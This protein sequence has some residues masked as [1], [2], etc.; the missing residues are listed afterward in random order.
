MIRAFF[1]AAALAYS[2]A[3]TVVT[4]AGSGS[5]GFVDGPG[6]GAS[7]RSPAGVAVDASGNVF[8]GDTDNNSL[9]KITPGGVVTS[10]AGS[11]VASFADGTGAGAAF[12]WPAGVAVDDASGKVVVA[13]S[14]NH[15]IRL[16][17]PGGVVSTL[18]GDGYTDAFGAG[19]FADGPGA[20]A[21]FFLPMGVVFDAN[22]NAFVADAMNNRIRK[23]TPGGAVSTVAGSG[24]DAF[25][26]GIG[27]GAAFSGPASIAVDAYDNLLVAEMFGH[28]IRKVS[29]GGMVRTIAGDGYADNNGAGRWADGVGTAA[30]FSS[31]SGV[32]VAASGNIVVSDS[33]NNRI[34]VVTPGGVVGTLA[35]NGAAAFA[36]GAGATASFYYPVGVAVD[37]SGNVFVADEGNHRIR[38]VTPPSETPSGTISGTRSGTP[39]STPSGTP[40]ATLSSS[41]SGTPSATLSGTPSST[42]SGTR[43][44][45]L[46]GTPSGTRSG[47]PSGTLTATPSASVT[48]SA[49]PSNSPTIS[50]SPTPSASSLACAP[51]SFVAPGTYSCAR[52]PA[53]T[54]A[55]AA[56]SNTA[57]E[58]CP[59]PLVANANATACA[60]CPLHTR[61]NDTACTPCPADVW[62]EGGRELPCLL[63]GQCLGNLQGCRTGHTGFLCASCA[64][65][66][67]KA[68][69]NFCSPC[70]AQLW[71]ALAWLGGA[72]ALLG[73]VGLFLQRQLRSTYTGLAIVLS[74]HQLILTLV[75]DQ[76]MRLA[77]LNRLAVLAL[78]A[79]FKW[80]L[81]FAGLVFGFNTASAATECAN[82]GWAF[83]QMWGVVA[84]ATFF[85]L[86]L[87]LCVDLYAQ[88]MAPSPIAVAEW[89]VWDAMDALLP[90]AVQASWQALS[91]E[92]I[93]GEL[94]LLSEPSTRV[95]EYPHYAIY[96]A[97]VF[98]V[99]LNLCVTHKCGGG[100]GAKQTKK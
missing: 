47:T 65:H 11:G 97:S 6:A 91:S 38:L 3:Q 66:H 46:S 52:C 50:L 5:Q 39:S 17:T 95:F 56:G 83:A 89:R 14:L 10:L 41:P 21:S 88:R 77:L 58:P 26:D 32:A 24:A 8:V 87:T 25:A 31:P 98:I 57:C 51:G 30:S 62:C 33:A 12:Y 72:A 73:A 53:N 96:C 23:V 42:P 28:R 37:A 84:G 100:G 7:F 20:A 90:L 18:A 43:S 49:S 61:S 79:D 27:A 78:P 35:G 16:V 54:I 40:S 34:R 75:W 55:P 2:S 69:T 85:G 59:F 93:D 9:R 67:Y 92:S 76:V 94:R 71:Q 99:L 44:G 19:R 45:T 70:G 22:G 86:L 60:P 82:S 48:P 1:V 74:N 36:D 80:A 81:A 63:P 68:P 64:P 15:R 4:F 29:P 13:D